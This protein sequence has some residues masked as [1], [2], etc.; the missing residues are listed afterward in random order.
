MKPYKASKSKILEK[1]RESIMSEPIESKGIKELAENVDNPD[2]AAKLIK[3]LDH[4]IKSKKN[5]VLSIAYH[6]GEIFK[7]FK[8]NNKY[9]STVSAFKII[10]TT[11]N[12]KID[13]VKFID[14][15]PKMQTSWISLHYLKNNFS[16]I[17]EVCQEHASE[18]Q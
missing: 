10:K 17:K 4:M 13:I 16:V 18:F 8:T 2:D 15:C 7:R 1:L 9:I 12:F 5:N 6:Q 11:I 14:M 3:K